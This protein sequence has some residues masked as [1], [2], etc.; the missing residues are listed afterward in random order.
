MPD[1]RHRAGSGEEQIGTQRGPWRTAEIIDQ[2][3][4]AYKL[5]DA[6]EERQYLLITKMMKA[7]RCHGTIIRLCRLMRKNILLNQ[8]Y[9]RVVREG[10]LLTCN[11][12]GWISNFKTGDV[13][14]DIL[15]TRPAANG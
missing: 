15:A 4:M 1:A 14:R 3:A 5:S 13:Q 11:R 12:N 2:H 9:G 6:L 10:K 7:H 8:M